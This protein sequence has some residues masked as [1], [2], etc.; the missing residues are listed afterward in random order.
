MMES[1]KSFITKNSL[2]SCNDT[3]IVGL[4]G[5]PDSVFLLHYLKSL[6]EQYKLT[7]IAGHL[8]HEW[9]SNSAQDAEFC[10]NLAQQ[11]DIEFVGMK[12]SELGK[13]VKYNG[14]QEEVGRK[15]RRHFFEQIRERYNAQSI[16][17]AHHAHDQQETFFIRLLRGS[18]LSGLIGMK[19]KDGFYIRP[20]LDISKTEILTYLLANNIDYVIDPTNT[21]NAYLRN[22][23]RNQ[24]IPALQQADTRFEQN[25]AKTVQHLQN[26]EQFLQKLTEQT[27]NQITIKQSDSWHLNLA[28]FF[29]LDPFLQDRVLLYWLIQE[30]VSFVP[31]AGLLQEIKR[32]LKSSGN[33]PHRLYT[34][35]IEKRNAT[36]CINKH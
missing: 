17:L 11:L 5:G 3:I 29:N 10:K 14:S 13:T 19:P 31:S 28:Q 4:S 20:L 35:Y 25:F 27:F 2:I 18:S 34:W 12:A 9:R 24:I 26:T 36:A 15:L 1:I 7:L 30:K 22:R 23:I 6:A 32:F 16:A 21:D 8:D 33:S